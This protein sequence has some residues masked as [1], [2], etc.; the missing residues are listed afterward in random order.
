M[1]ITGCLMAE[2]TFDIS[3]SGQ[4]AP[5][6]DLT[7]VK[8]NVAK[9]FK[10]EVHNIEIMFSGNRVVIKRNLGQ[11]TAMKYLA[12]MKNAGAMCEL[13]ENKPVVGREYSA[14][15]PPP[16]PQP[17]P[18]PG[19]ASLTPQ[20]TTS[21]TIPGGKPVSVSDMDSVTIAPPGETLMEYAQVAEPKIDI[22]ALSI[23]DSRQNLVEHTFV[24]EPV[25]D[26]SSMSLDSSGDDLVQQEHIAKPEIDISSLSLDEAGENLTEHKETPPLEVDT[27]NM[28]MTPRI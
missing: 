14:E 4:L 23:D 3:F 15:N 20:V 2:S 22:S 26:I 17:D 18:S 11:Q 24:P 21:N 5:G 16:I 27:S 13:T 9:L 10:T 19:T 8:N 28:S 7:Q 25:I 1:T 6:A 12:A